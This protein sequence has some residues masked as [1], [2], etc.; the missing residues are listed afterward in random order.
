MKYDLVLVYPPS[1]DNPDAKHGGARVA[2]FDDENSS[3]VSEDT[4]LSL[5]P[6]HTLDLDEKVETANLPQIPENAHKVELSLE[7]YENIFDHLPDTD[8]ESEEGVAKRFW[9]FDVKNF[10]KEMLGKLVFKLHSQMIF[11]KKTVFH[12]YLKR[13]V[14][15]HVND[16][17]FKRKASVNLWRPLENAEEALNLAFWLV[18]ITVV[19]DGLTCALIHEQGNGPLVMP[20]GLSKVSWVGQESTHRYNVDPRKKMLEDKVSGKSL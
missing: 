4:G 18:A 13:K 20:Q 11:N 1:A 5:L 19:T 10:P 6:L 14:L 2:I 15:E 17:V 3:I 12:P 16:M 9:E 7:T 8:D